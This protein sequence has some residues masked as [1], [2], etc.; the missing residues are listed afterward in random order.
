[1]R[2][3]GTERDRVWSRQEGLPNWNQQTAWDTTVLQVGCGG[4]G[5]EILHSLV[6]KG[7]GELHCFDGDTVDLSNLNRQRFTVQD[8]G[9]DKADRLARNLVQDGCMGSRVIGYPYYFEAALERGFDLN[10][11]VVICGVDSDLSRRAV[12]EWAISKH[13]PALFCAVSRDG[14]QC[15]CLVQ[16]PGEACFGC[17]LPHAINNEVTPCPGVPA[18]I[19]PLK[20]A[21]ALTSFAVD[22][23]VMGRPIGWNYREIR[24]AGFMPELV[25]TVPRNPDCPLC[26]KNRGD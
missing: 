22:C 12:A 5:G 4:L 6:K 18:I 1:L 8:L 13:I 9:K 17:I 19:D 10:P 16:H 20:L 3:Q 24:L 2:N 11:D 21:A 14:D 15:Y 25:R 26:G 7:Y 23:L